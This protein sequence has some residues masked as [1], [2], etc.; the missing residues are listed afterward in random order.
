M[1]LI[2]L[3]CGLAAA[4]SLWAAAGVRD[5]AQTIGRDAE[6]SVALGLRMAATLS[7]MDAAVLADSLTDGGAATGTSLAYSI[8]RDRLGADMVEAARNVTYG[9]AE[10]APLRALQQATGMFER[11]VMEAR[12][13]GAGDSFITSQR[14]QW[15][16]RVGN[17]FAMPEARALAAA[18]ADELERRYATYRAGSLLKGLLLGTGGFVLLNLSLILTQG[19]LTRRTRR[20]INP[21]LVLATAV[22][23]VTALWFATAVVTEREALRSAKNDAYDSLRVLFD[24]KAEVNQLRSAMSLWLLDP[25]TRP[26]AQVRLDQAAKNLTGEPLTQLARARLVADGQFTPANGDVPKPELGGL[27]GQELKNVTFGRAEQEAAVASVDKLASAGAM[28]QRVQN[29]QMGDRQAAVSLWLEAKGGAGAFA[30][31]QSAIDRTIA[32]NQGAFDRSIAQTLR[33]AADMPWAISAAAAL[34]ALLS[35]IGLWQRLREYR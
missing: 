29:L 12:Y 13:I 8:A 23:T 30:E 19:W 20:V 33:T 21:P 7:D 2:L 16:S 24:A 31:A 10:A 3:L 1:A 6:P 22:T 5:A 35:M 9:E 27:L 17:R 25:A 11:A 14:V 34:V 26:S 4:G 28:V 18:N 32:I 15:A